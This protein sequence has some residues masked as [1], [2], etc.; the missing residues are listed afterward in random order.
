M[1][2]FVG[3]F[4]SILIPN[5]KRITDKIIPTSTKKN[6]SIIN[7]NPNKPPIVIIITKVV[8]TVQIA[9]PPI[10]ADTIPTLI[11]A[12]KW[13]KPNTG[14]EIPSKKPTMPVKLWAIAGNG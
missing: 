11:I 9:F 4:F 2:N 6:S 10:C 8:G 3:I 13:S 14:W 1:I 7:K 12:R 5:P